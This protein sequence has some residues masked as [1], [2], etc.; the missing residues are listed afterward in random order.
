MTMLKLLICAL[1]LVTEVAP[2][3]SQVRQNFHED[4]EAGINKQINLEL[5]ASYVYMSM[6][7]YFGHDDVSLDGFARLFLRMSEEERQHANVLVDY[8]NKRGGHV[9]YREVKQP[10]QTQ[11]GSGLDAMESALELEKHMNQ[12]LLD[13][14]RTADRHRDPQMQ[15]FLNYHFLKEEVTRIKQLGDYVTKLKRVGDGLGEYNFDRDVLGG[16]K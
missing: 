11:W 14:Y 9:V 16:G 7:S 5:Y 15:D 6:A 3:P 2:A 8:Q 12:A 10:D 4:S 13:L 1:F